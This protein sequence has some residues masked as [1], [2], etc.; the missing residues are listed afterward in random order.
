MACENGMEMKA[1][2]P[3]YYSFLKKQQQELH[4]ENKKKFK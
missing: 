3:L 4:E 2:F 1:L